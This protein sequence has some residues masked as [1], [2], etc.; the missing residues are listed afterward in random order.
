MVSDT[1][2]WAT[3]GTRGR[4]GLWQFAERDRKSAANCQTAGEVSRVSQ[5]SGEGAG[6]R[7]ALG[8]V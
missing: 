2:K 1:E 8:W 4:G 7:L 5:G 3:D 6:E